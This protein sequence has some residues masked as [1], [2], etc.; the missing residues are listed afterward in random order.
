MSCLTL[1]AL[2]SR[3]RSKIETLAARPRAVCY[4]ALDRY[5][6]T[7]PAREYVAVVAWLGTFFPFQLAWVLE[8]ARHA[9]AN[10]GRQIGISHASAA[11]AV[12]WSVYHGEL[13]VIISKTD[14]AALE[15]FIKARKH[16]EL[17][18][19]FGSQLA[20]PI[21]DKNNELWFRGGGRIKSRP[22]T[23]AQGDTGNVIIDEF[24]YHENQQATWDRAA[25]A[26]THGSFRIRVVS[27]PNGISNL[28]HTLVA[29]AVP[30]DD[31]TPEDRAASRWIMHQIPMARAILEGMPV[32]IES[33]RQKAHGD[34]R[35]FAQLY[36]CAFLDG[37]Q[38]YIQSQYVLDCQS[39]NLFVQPGRGEW[40]AGLDIGRTNDLTVLVVVHFDGAVATVRAVRSVKRTD[41]DAL[42]GLV[43][44]AFRNYTLR[45]LCVDAT[46]MGSFPVDEM[47][48]RFG[49]QAVEGVNFGSAGAK[50]E[51]ATTLYSAF[52]DKWL[53]IPKTDA[54]L[55]DVTPGSADGLSK[56]VMA[57]RRIIGPSGIIRYDAPHTAEGHADRAWALALALYGITNRPGIRTVHF[58]G[59]QT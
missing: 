19:K 25:A 54:A 49:R 42:H 55:R 39:D 1:E 9:V 57:L 26:T 38:Q 6:R 59:T 10:K 31:A 5:K 24:A 53:R 30:V 23:G 27:T 58:A 12:L 46:G 52:C 36:E 37:E 4:D 44:E 43:N 56:D 28:F 11:S 7:L 3:L 47:Q 13:T 16:V 14:D 20:E 15:T 29:G 2:E 17:L 45:R 35:V 33:C 22:S 32:D 18:M 34:E 8:T 50:D 48:R 21:R 41:H 51:L 40:Y